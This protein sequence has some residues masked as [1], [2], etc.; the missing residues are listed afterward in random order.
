MPPQSAPS[1]IPIGLLLA[2]QIC[3]APGFSMLHCLFFLGL[4]II[5]CWLKPVP[6]WHIGR[7]WDST[8]RIWDRMVTL[9]WKKWSHSC[10]RSGWLVNAS[11][12]GPAA[13]QLETSSIAPNSCQPKMHSVNSCSLLAGCSCALWSG[14]EG[15]PAPDPRLLLA[16]AGGCWSKHHH[17]P[18]LAGAEPND[19]EDMSESSILAMEEYLE[20]RDFY[21]NQSRCDVPLE[22]VLQGYG[23]I[24]IRFLNM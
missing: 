22:I 16:K 21:F 5:W 15:H 4:G 20:Q 13:P 7:K 12:H 10:F 23:S 8:S 9:A 11:C 1:L 18:L 24:R 2:R 17:K 3:A 19:M 14:K 6:T